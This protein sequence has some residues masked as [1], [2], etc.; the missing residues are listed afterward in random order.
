MLN[1]DY[2]DSAVTGNEACPCVPEGK[3]TCLLLDLFYSAGE[4][5]GEVLLRSFGNMALRYYDG[6]PRPG[7]ATWHEYRSRHY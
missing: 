1:R 7:Q 2:L 4:A 3:S 5:T 6:T